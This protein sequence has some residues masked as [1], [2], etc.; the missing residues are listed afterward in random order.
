MR[1]GL[2]AVLAVAMAAM[3]LGCVEDETGDAGDAELTSCQR[4][5]RL[6]DGEVRDCEPPRE[7]A[8]ITEFTG[9]ITQLVDAND[10]PLTA[11]TRSAGIPSLVAGIAVG[12]GADGLGCPREFTASV[13]VDDDVPS[14]LVAESRYRLV[15]NT[16]CGGGMSAERVQ[17]RLP[18]LAVGQHTLRI[19]TG[20]CLGG[21]CFMIDPDVRFV[22]IPID[23]VP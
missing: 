5:A 18:G 15:L 9:L 8:A 20:G 11:L 4:R 19:D 7:D 21:D 3:G 23:V 2:G 12:F 10:E 14:R 22:D 6:V 13:S 16:T 17:L 1:M